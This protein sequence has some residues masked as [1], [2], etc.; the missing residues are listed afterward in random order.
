MTL[1]TQRMV[2]LALV[3]VA[4]ACIVARIVLTRVSP[5]RRVLALSRLLA[6]RG[7]GFA[8]A[9]LVLSL[10][11]GPGHAG[12]RALLEP[13][14]RF[15]AL[16]AGYVLAAGRLT[17]ESGIDEDDTLTW[18]VGAILVGLAAVWGLFG[19]ATGSERV[20]TPGSVLLSLSE[21]VLGAAVGIFVFAV[22]CECLRVRNARRDLAQARRAALG[23]AAVTWATAT[24]MASLLLGGAGSLL[25]WGICWGWDPVEL[26]RLALVLLY[27]A[28]GH[29]TTER[30]SNAGRGVVCL[31]AVGFSVF[32]LLGSPLL[33]RWM[34]L[35]S[36]FVG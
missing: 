6:R 15:V 16:C 29:G 14:D 36:R 10:V 22:L 31:L 2:H 18:G 24:A 35:P 12:S 34:E 17:R 13:Q 23:E 4:W 28:L 1:E 25:A 20:L 5:D 11:L 30:A 32:V 21:V 27:A 33:V 7:W 9:A 26:W 8:V 3:W 19:A